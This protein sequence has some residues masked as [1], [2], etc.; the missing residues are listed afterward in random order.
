MF[1]VPWEYRLLCSVPDA[2]CSHTHNA[3]CSLEHRCMVAVSCCCMRQPMLSLPH[4]CV[5]PQE[6]SLGKRP[7]QLPCSLQLMHP[8]ESYGMFRGMVCLL[9]HMIAFSGCIVLS[10]QP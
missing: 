3:D 9:Q 6:G 8:L 5:H 1:A 10:L 4:K 7:Q 2:I